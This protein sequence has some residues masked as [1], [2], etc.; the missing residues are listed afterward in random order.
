MHRVNTQKRRF[1][2]YTNEKRI[3]S[4]AGLWDAPTSGTVYSLILMAH[5]LAGSGHDV[6]IACQVD[7]PFV[8]EGVVFEPCQSESEL[9]RLVE[10]EAEVFDTVVVVG[11]AI[12]EITE[13]I[14]VLPHCIYWLHNWTPFAELVSQV[15]RFQFKQVVCVS[16]YHLGYYLTHAVRRF[17][18]FRRLTY[19]NNPVDL[20]FSA[21]ARVSEANG[22]EIKVAFIGYPSRGKGFDK[23]ISMMQGLSQLTDRVCVLHVFGD[24]TLYNNTSQADV[25]IG[26]HQPSVLH[27]S[28]SRRELYPLL[29]E[30]DFAVSGLSGAE[31]FCLSLLEAAVCGVVPVTVNS[32]GQVSFL[33]SSNAIIAERVSD[34]PAKVLKCFESSTGYRALS[35]QA[36]RLYLDFAPELIADRW[37]QLGRQRSC[38]AAGLLV[39]GVF[40]WFVYSRSRRAWFTLGKK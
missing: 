36:R 31:T 14:R 15:E 24:T 25:E 38:R 1:L 37:M 22:A 13:A 35:T 5:A 16:R 19:I 3:V 34:L 40:M 26:A 28:V 10:A 32:G 18:L 30:C 6:V 11:H 17:S 12:N 21:P 23:V 8:A 4:Y 7:E 29:A 39:V 2:F 9:L 33:N 20:R 27:G